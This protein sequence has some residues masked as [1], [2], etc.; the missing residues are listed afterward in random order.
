M[1]LRDIA[2]VL[3]TRPEIIKMAPVIHELGQRARIIHS[4]Q[5]YD[6]E[7]S[8]QHFS[9]LG[10]RQPDVILDGIGGA[11][12]ADQ[13]SRMLHALIAHFE[14]DRP[15]VVLVQG[16]TNTVSAGAQAAHYLDIPVVHVE[17]GLRSYDR[18][19]PEEINRIIT[20]AL[21]DVHCAPTWTNAHNLIREGV[22]AERIAVT[23]NTVVEATLRAVDSPARTVDSWFQGPRPDRYAVATIH[24]PENTDSSTALERVLQGLAAVDVP[25]V[26]LIHPRTRAAISRFKLDHLLQPLLV[27]DAPNSQDFLRL[28]GSA[29][30]LVS[31]SGGV[32]EEATVIKT[33]LAVI[34]RSTE[35]PEAIDSGFAWLIKPDMNIADEVN[36]ILRNSR[37]PGI[38]AASAS[39]F[40]DGTASERIARIAQ[41]IADGTSAVEAAVHASMLHTAGAAA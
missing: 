30:V 32:Q 9:S 12:R 2:I 7:L 33:P 6:Q 28:A 25:V 29:A 31:D 39:P 16:D 11:G 5:H 19:M 38:L 13:I 41:E 22:P 21:A 36:K 40:G 26:F 20:G 18:G 23:G 4:G 37:I 17:A 14:Q 35:R 3:G 15:K 1:T 34:R 8:G 24:R 10:L 27:R